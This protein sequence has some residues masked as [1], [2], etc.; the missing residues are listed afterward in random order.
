MLLSLDLCNSI[1]RLIKTNFIF[2]WHLQTSG[3]QII[4]IIRLLQG[5]Y[6][7]YLNDRR[8]LLEN[9]LRFLN[10]LLRQTFILCLFWAGRRNSQEFV[11]LALSTLGFFIGRQLL[12]FIPKFIFFEI[13]FNLIK[14]FKEAITFNILADF[15]LDFLFDFWFIRELNMSALLVTVFLL[16]FWIITILNMNLMVY[17]INLVGSRKIY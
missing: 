13:S 5:G 3:Q 7:F 8:L 12:K 9:I 14:E 2:K 1:L 15:V 10:H 6:R 4:W 17:W 11:Y 16:I